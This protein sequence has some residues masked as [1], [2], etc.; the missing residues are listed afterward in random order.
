MMCERSKR[1]DRIGENMKCKEDDRTEQE[2][3][4]TAIGIG[5]RKAKDL[6][7]HDRTRNRIRKNRKGWSRTGIGEDNT[8]QNSNRNKNRK[9]K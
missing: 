5:I 4:R 7:G 3:M 8:E 2:K 1:Q 9:C 6:I